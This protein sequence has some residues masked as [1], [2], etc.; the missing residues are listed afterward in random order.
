MSQ[1]QK[2]MQKL[3]RRE[4]PSMG[5]GAAVRE[6]PRAMILIALTA[7]KADAKAALEAGADAV[8]IRA[9]A[10]K[11]AAAVEA[12][13]ETSNSVGVM[14][15]ALDEDGAAALAKAGCDFV[16]S[17]LEGTESV[18]VDTDRMGH[19]LIASE[20]MEDNTLRAIAPLGLDALYVERSAGGTMLANQ[21]G[22]VRLATF[23][24]TP[25]VVTVAAKASVAELR[26]LRDSGVGGVI[27]PEGASAADL[28]ALI[29]AL[30]AVPA[31]KKARRDGGDMAIVPSAAAGH[32]E[33]DDEEEEGDDDE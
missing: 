1:L 28:K 5:F 22:L 25:L 9:E 18:A 16:I 20:G 31:P 11:A 14:S 8:V 6:Q 26:V 2:K 23:A 17:S 29:K 24:S 10:A 7:N 32:A 12:V 3:Q 19:I 4:G 13:A 27:A 30:I 21:L 33:H 15:E